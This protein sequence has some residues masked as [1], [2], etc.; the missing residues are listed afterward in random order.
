MRLHTPLA[1]AVVL[2]VP[3]LVAAERAQVLEGYSIEPERQAPSRAGVGFFRW[4]YNV[5]LGAAIPVGDRAYAFDRGEEFT[6]CFDLGV[7]LAFDVGA[8]VQ[9]GFVGRFGFGGVD[10]ELYHEQVVDLLGFSPDTVR[11][12]VIQSG[13]RLRVYWFERRHVRPFVSVE[14]TFT[15]MGLTARHDVGCADGSCEASRETVMSFRYRAASLAPGLGLR[16]DVGLRARPGLPR[17]TR[18]LAVSVQA[19]YCVNFWH[20]ARLEVRGLHARQADVEGLR[21]DHVRVAAGVGV[22]F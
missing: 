1:V 11:A 9:L 12:M 7:D 16:Y 10:E 5:E 14:C 18:V 15:M 21:L 22:M 2:A 17:Y 8:H 13:P 20:D 4:G 19:S 6:P 3:A